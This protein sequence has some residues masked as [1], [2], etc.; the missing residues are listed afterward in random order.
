[1]KVTYLFNSGFVV[2]LDKHILIFDY[3]K[4]ALDTLDKNKKVYV[5][6]SHNHSDHFNKEIYNFNHSN[7][8]YILDSG[9]DGEGIKV[10][11]HNDYQIDDLKIHTLI[12]TDE[13]VAFIVE[14][15]G[16]R[17]YHS[18]DLNWWDWDGEPKEWLANQERVFKEEINSISDLD[19]D[20]MFV[21]LDIRLEGN[22]SKSIDYIENKCK[23]KTI[24]PMHCFS[25]HQQMS[26]LVDQ[27]PLNKYH[28]ILKIKKR[29]QIFDV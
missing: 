10:K 23:V 25:H 21:P 17:I 20:L 26:E 8:T 22:A 7:I 12:S 13:G 4:G 5:F 29:H 14:V 9:C 6:S 27:P 1:M 3:F 28:N 15:E 16:K 18:G 11:P 19:F 24:I 2:E